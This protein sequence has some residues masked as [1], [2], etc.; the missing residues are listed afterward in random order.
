MDYQESSIHIN[1]IE[2]INE[3]HI[4]LM[5]REKIKPVENMA[6]FIQNGLKK[7]EK[8]VYITD[9]NSIDDILKCFKYFGIDTDKE[10]GNGRL[11]VIEGGNTFLEQNN[12]F[13]FKNALNVLEKEL[14]LSKEQGFTGLRAAGE[15]TWLL[16]N[17]DNLTQLLDY[18]I[19]VNNI[20]EEHNVKLI[21]MYNI[22]KFP[23]KILLHA[24]YSHP[25]IIYGDWIKYNDKNIV[26]EHV[27]HLKNL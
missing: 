21:C 3:K 19:D 11:L 13:D 5:Y 8:C 10:I 14:R 18:E 27:H 4:S 17:E 23:L 16:N 1:N 24:I 22:T 20:I 6:T 26:K 25:A 15:M 9:D 12:L 7:N 2:N